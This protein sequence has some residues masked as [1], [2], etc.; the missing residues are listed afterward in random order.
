MIIF[1]SSLVSDS[2]PEVGDVFSERQTDRVMAFDVVAKAS[3][4]PL[5]TSPLVAGDFSG[6][7]G[8]N[9]AATSTRTRKVALFEGKDEFGRLQPLLGTAEPATDYLGNPVNWPDDPKYIAAGL[10][11]PMEGAI[12]WHSPTT[13]NPALGS[14]EIWEIYNVTGDAH[15]LHVHLVHFEVLD[16]QEIVWDTNTD[17]DGFIVGAPADDGTY[18]ETQPTVQHNSDSAFPPGSVDEVTGL[19]NSTYG[20]GFKVVNPTPSGVLLDTP[21]GYVENAPKDMVIALPGQVAR[22]KATF[23]KPGRYVWHCHI[24]SHEDHEMMRVMHVGPGA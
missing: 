13:E 15:P 4:D 10:V 18:L 14:T 22:I 23:D 6:Q 19:S 3:V 11:G 7:F 1:R 9:L 24:L 12:A 17:E 5:L 8:G 20:M 21:A 2:D 16:R